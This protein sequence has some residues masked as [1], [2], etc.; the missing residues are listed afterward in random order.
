[1]GIGLGLSPQSKNY[2]LISFTPLPE[3]AVKID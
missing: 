2:R 1:M 3:W